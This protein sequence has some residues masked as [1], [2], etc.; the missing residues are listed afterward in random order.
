MAIQTSSKLIQAVREYQAGCNEAFDTIYYESAPY[1]TTCVLS[2]LHKTVGNVSDDLQQDI[3]QDTYLTIAQK[4]WELNNPAAFLQWAGRIATHTAQRT[5]QKDARRYAMEI[6]DEDMTLEV[7]DES[8]IPEDILMNREKQQMVR[9][10][11]QELP[12]NQYMCV[13]EYFY[14]G[15]K[16]RE[17]ADKLEMP[18]NTVKTNLSRAKKKLRTVIETKVQAAGIQYQDMAWLLLLLLQ[19]DVHTLVIPA[20]QHQMLLSS[21]HAKLGFGAAATATASAAGV[22]GASASASAGGASSS[23]SAAAAAGGKTVAT[24]AAAIALAGTLTAGAAIGIP[25]AT[26]D[27]Q[28]IPEGALEYNGHSYFIYGSFYDGAYDGPQPQCNSWEEAQEFCESLGGHLAVITTEE[29]NVA[30]YEY[31]V[32][33]DHT[34]VYLGL[35]RTEGQ[36]Q[37]VTGED[38]AF[39][40]GL[41]EGEDGAYGVLYTDPW[42]WYDSHRNCDIWNSYEHGSWDAKAYD[43]TST[44]VDGVAFLCEWE[45]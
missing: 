6:S 1:I 29:E 32:T 17:I 3:L 26:R 42:L 33:T 22:G 18:V 40:H 24:K 8:F 23:A 7:M 41:P 19:G 34:Q 36:W 30:L 27:R 5:W 21:L 2:V 39:T 37:W 35:Y 14:N 13:V 20:T 45:D 25:L 31:M 12:T 43:W 4:L 16:E 10:L 28:K 9:R 44:K 38:V 15:L 11:L